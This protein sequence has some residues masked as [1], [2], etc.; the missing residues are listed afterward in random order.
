MNR[1]QFLIL[2]LVLVVF[3]GVGMALFWKDIAAYRESDARIGAWLLPELKVS[4]VAEFRLQDAQDEVTLV[5][6]GDAWQVKERGGY[7]ANVQEIG[8]LMVRLI[9]LKVTQS[10][11]IGASLLPRIDLAEPGTAQEGVGTVIEMKNEAGDRLA[12]IV[13]GRQVLKK[14]PLNP[15]PG[16][17]DGVPAGRYVLPASGGETIVVVSDPLQNAVAA[18]GRWLDKTFFEAERIRTLTVGPEKGPPSWIIT[19]DEEWGQWKFAKGAGDLDPS[20][21]VSAVNKLGGIRFTDVIPEPQP[22][23][24][25]EPMVAVAETFDRLTYTVRFAKLKGRDDYQLAFTVTGSPPTKRVPEKDEDAEDRER[26]DKSFAENLKAL[27]KRL[28]TEKAL[29]KWTYV[30]ARSEVEPLLKTRKEMLARKPV[31]PQ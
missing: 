16:A 12:R 20:A 6:S 22:G 7:T 23:D 11:Q 29:A 9:D 31:K 1:K 27:E 3:G 10:E 14:D 28:A 13:V 4:E 5:R 24:S 8:D 19:R 21:A 18:P 15:L 2:A 25:E 26:R 17:R 30:V